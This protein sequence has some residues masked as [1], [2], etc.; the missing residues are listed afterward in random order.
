MLQLLHLSDLHLGAH[1]KS[2]N[3]L[4]MRMLAA[5]ICQHYAGPDAPVILISGDLTNNGTR[6]EFSQAVKILG[7]FRKAGFR[8]LVCPGNHDVG[9]MG[10]TFYPSAQA[11]FQQQVL[12]ELLGIQRARTATNRMAEFY[13]RVDHIHGVACIGL[14][15]ANQEDHLASG[16]IG[17]RQLIRLRS[18]LAKIPAEMPI[19]VYVH[20]HV[21]QWVHAMR[22]WDSK[23]LLNVLDGR[24]NLLC[25]GHKHQPRVWDALSRK[26]EKTGIDVLVS[27]GQSTAPKRRSWPPKFPYVRKLTVHPHGIVEVEELCL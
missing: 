27:S 7:R 1:R 10:N 6:D 14:D 13:P 19:V 9:P 26:S 23:D 2:R 18:A 4:R 25:F 16:R 17:R 15:S 8:L 11:N 20:H 21:F 5:R 12:G 24:A 22:L 3:N